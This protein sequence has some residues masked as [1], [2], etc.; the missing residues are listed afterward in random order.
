MLSP[1]LARITAVCSD[2]CLYARGH[3]L[4]NARNLTEL[5]LDGSLLVLSARETIR[6]YEPAARNAGEVNT[7]LFC[8]L[9]NLERVSIKN[10]TCGR[11]SYHRPISELMLIKMARNH[12][13]LR[14]LR[15]DLSKENV[16]M[17]KSQLPEITFVS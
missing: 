9:V 3:G 14:W 5:I 12:P 6:H 13:N 2:K 8:M 15:S 10:A 11:R 7:F 17:L 4:K 16:A 1:K